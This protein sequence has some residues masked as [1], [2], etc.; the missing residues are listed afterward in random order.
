MNIVLCTDE[1]YARYAAVVIATTLIHC[2]QRSHLHFYLL[3]P[4]LAPKTQQHLLD[5]VEQYGARLD[6]VTAKQELFDGADL[7]RFGACTLMRLYMHHYLPADCQRAIYLDCDLLILADITGLWNVDLDGK[8]VGA[9]IDLCSPK[10]HAQTPTRPA[11]CNA[12]VLVVDLQKWREHR[13]GEQALAYLEHHI[14]TLRYLDQDALN[15]VLAGHWHPVGLAWNFQPAAYTALEK[16][17]GYLLH[18]KTELVQAVHHPKIV[19]FIGGTKPWHAACT[20]PLQDLFIHFS[21]STAW[22]LNKAELRA[23]L[24]RK[25]RIHRAT[26]QWKTWRRRSKLQYRV[27]E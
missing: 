26:K 5:M 15:H 16:N 8:A 3:T 22:P 14:N 12:G 10:A 19:H 25:Q 6:I 2:H 18:R 13:I 20:H 21:R 23:T 11:Y 4:G 1:N 7:G 24:S 9:V 27:P 17:Y